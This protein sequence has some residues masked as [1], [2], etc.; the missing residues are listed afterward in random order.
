[1]SLRFSLLGLLG[2]V[3]LASLGCAALVQPGPRWLCVLVSLTAAAVIWQSL[4]AVLQGG[5]SR[6]SAVGWLVFTVTYLALVMGPWL[7]T[8][9]GPQLLSTKLLAYAQVQWR[10]ED[11]GSFGATVQPVSVWSYSSGVVDRNN[12][13]VDGT[14]STIVGSGGVAMFPYPLQISQPGNIN[15]FLLS[16]HWLFAWV[17]GWLGSVI[18]VHCWR[19][20]PDSASK[21]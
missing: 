4:R 7:Q 17:A 2:L 11:L 13:I 15:Y 1:M 10:K 6:A 12:G 3:T 18:A 9:V 19:R 16:G 14:S 8:H 20:R 21:T 5:Q